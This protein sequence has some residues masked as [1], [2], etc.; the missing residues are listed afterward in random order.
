M[1]KVISLLIEFDDFDESK[2]T[3]DDIEQYLQ[4]EYGIGCYLDHDNP[5]F[6]IGSEIIESYVYDKDVIE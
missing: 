6:H 3:D 5:L 1:K 2:V 4:F